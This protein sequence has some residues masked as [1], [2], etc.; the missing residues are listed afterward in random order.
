MATMPRRIRFDIEWEEN[1]REEDEDEV[2]T[3]KGWYIIGSV[4]GGPSVSIGP[5][6]YTDG[7][8]TVDEALVAIAAFAEDRGFEYKPPMI[9][10]FLR[11]EDDD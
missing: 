6:R 8:A 9:Q 11:A 10:V 7:F 3:T 2:T 5:D 1:L 4:P